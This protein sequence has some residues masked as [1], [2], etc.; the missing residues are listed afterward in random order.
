MAF[1]LIRADF[2]AHGRKIG[3][4]GFWAMLVYRYGR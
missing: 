3:A 4:Q 1:D 2:R